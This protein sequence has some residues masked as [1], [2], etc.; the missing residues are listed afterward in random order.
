MLIP[1]LKIHLK[2]F[3]G[4]V[5]KPPNCYIMYMINLKTGSCGE[6]LKNDNTWNCKTMF[7]LW[8]TYGQQNQWPFST[9]KKC[10]KKEQYWF[11]SHIDILRSVSSLHLESIPQICGCPFQMFYLRSVNSTVKK[12]FYPPLITFILF[13]LSFNSYFCF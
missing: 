8:M 6:N 2:I 7:R 5:T 9:Y 1:W 3:I 4:E 11:S 12:R 13:R 10:K